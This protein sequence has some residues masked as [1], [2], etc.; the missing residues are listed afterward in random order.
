[1]SALI[2]KHLGLTGAKL[3]SL[4]SKVCSAADRLEVR[5]ATPIFIIELARL[6]NRKLFESE[7]FK[8][9]E[10]APKREKDDFWKTK[11]EEITSALPPESSYFI[12]NDIL[13]VDSIS[14]LFPALKIVFRISA[15]TQ[16]INLDAPVTELALFPHFPRIA[17]AIDEIKKHAENLSGLKKNKLP[18]YFFVPDMSVFS[19]K[20]LLSTWPESEACCN[21]MLLYL[22]ELSRETFFKIVMK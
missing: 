11:S 19:Q 13:R 22:E 16:L 21:D 7:Y 6:Y 1:V 15:F 8:K 9:T 20:W 5:N 12:Q 14:R 2:S 3:D 4:S 10:N 17:A 18:L